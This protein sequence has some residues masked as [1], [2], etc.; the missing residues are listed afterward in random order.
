MSVDD[1]K[2]VTADV[3]AQKKQRKGAHDEAKLSILF[4]K[5]N[6]CIYKCYVFFL[7]LFPRR[8]S[9]RVSVVSE[10]TRARR[11][12]KCQRFPLRNTNDNE[13]V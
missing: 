8:L 7:P 12:G 1:V 6:T 2:D 5:I 9:A 13:L 4:V 10:H 3:V 11:D